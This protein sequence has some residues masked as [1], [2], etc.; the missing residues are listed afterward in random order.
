MV[1]P[2]VTGIL[3]II[4]GLGLMAVLSA[5]LYRIFKKSGWL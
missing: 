3:S 2:F 4:W 5:V 1:I